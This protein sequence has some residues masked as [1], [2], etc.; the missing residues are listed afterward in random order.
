MDLSWDH[1]NSSLQAKTHLTKVV[2]KQPA[3]R[4]NSWNLICRQHNFIRQMYRR[5]L[6]AWSMYQEVL[7]SQESPKEVSLDHWRSYKKV[8]LLGSC[9]PIGEVCSCFVVSFHWKQQA[10]FTLHELTAWVTSSATCLV[11]SSGSSLYVFLRDAQRIL[12]I[13]Y[14]PA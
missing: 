3:V 13:V 10:A 7:L 8:G 9:L 1:F 11:R 6:F 4:T 14:S 12:S 2:T 5:S